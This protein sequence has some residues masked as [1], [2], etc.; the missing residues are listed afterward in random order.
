M[1]KVKL[2]MQLPLVLGS[3]LLIFTGTTQYRKAINEV[4]AC[5]TN[6]DTCK[7]V[8]RNLTPDELITAKTVIQGIVTS[9]GLDLVVELK[10]SALHIKGKPGNKTLVQKDKYDKFLLFLKTLSRLP[11][12]VEYKTVCI[13]G[14]CQDEGINIQLEIKI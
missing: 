1:N 12:L 3:L 11:Y 14:Q 8:Y 5:N 4:L 2:F 9:Y 13:G 7:I 6:T 10:D